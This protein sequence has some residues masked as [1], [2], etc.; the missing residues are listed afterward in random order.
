MNTTLKNKDAAPK[1]TPKI[2]PK[3]KVETNKPTVAPKQ[4][5]KAEA[6]NPKPAQAISQ[7]DKKASMK[8]RVIDML[9]RPDGATDAE[10]VAEFKWKGN[11]VARGR[12][13][14]LGSEFKAKKQGMI[15]GKFTRTPSGDTAYK[16]EKLEAQAEEKKAA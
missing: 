6:A 4:P 15:I 8:Q 3:A 14:T 7:P 1:V 13:S 10:L 2:T 12:R 11:H 16:I 5:P 9:S